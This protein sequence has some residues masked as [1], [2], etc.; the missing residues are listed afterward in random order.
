MSAIRNSLVI[1]TTAATPAERRLP[2]GASD[3]SSSNS[4]TSRRSV[5][6]RISRTVAIGRP[7]GHRAPK[8]RF[9]PLHAAGQTSEAERPTVTT[10]PTACGSSG[11]T[12]RGVRS[13]RSLDRQRS[14]V[15]LALDE[16]HRYRTSPRAPDAD[17][18]DAKPEQW[19]PC[20]CGEQ[21]DHQKRKDERVGNRRNAVKLTDSEPAE[22][23]DGTSVLRYFST[24]SIR[25]TLSFGRSW[26]GGSIDTERRWEAR[27]YGGIGHRLG[28]KWTTIVTR[29]RPCAA[30]EAFASDFCNDDYYFETTV[31]EPLTHILSGF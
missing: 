25:V 29:L 13:P 17:E 28:T 1:L 10:R 11:V 3:S 5:S 30:G 6:S 26:I 23:R 12:S 2:G 14:S 19:G 27:D 22:N 7:W 8:S 24:V 9:S 21:R 20:E 16:R 4:A 31:G 18:R 15:A